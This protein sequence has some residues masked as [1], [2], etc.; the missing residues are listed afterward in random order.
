MT[1]EVYET[2]AWPSS[3]SPRVCVLHEGHAWSP[4]LA[5]QP[6]PDDKTSRLQ[7]RPKLG[8]SM[9]ANRMDVTLSTGTVPYFVLGDGRPLLYLHAAGGPQFTPF[10]EGLAQTHRVFV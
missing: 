7:R 6:S 2:N 4:N 10:L 8:G 9:P 3:I 5:S 1:A